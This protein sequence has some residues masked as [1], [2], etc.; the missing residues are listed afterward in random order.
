VGPARARRWPAWRSILRTLDI[1]LRYLASDLV[2]R[3]GLARAD[4]LLQGWS[5]DILGYGNLQL[6]TRG[7][8]VFERHPPPFV[9][10]SNHAS[11]LD[12]PVLLL[13]VPHTLR[14][15]T[16]AE[17]MRIPIWGRAMMRSGF[18]PIDRRDRARAIAQLETAK[19]LLARGVSVW[20]SPEGTRSRDGALQPF[21]KGGFHLA[22]DLGLPILP[23]WIEGTH[24]ALRPDSF[25]VNLDTPIE[26]R[27]GQPIA[28]GG[29]GA[30][31]LAELMAQV[32]AQL[33]EL[34]AM[35]GGPH[36]GAQLG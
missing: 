9:V 31:E 27:F 3:G 26:V 29:P 21:K 8:E 18:I 36:G 34:R 30:P 22:M 11:L 16:K 14:M 23:A 10:M 20:I 33:L 24:A 12:V 13:T 35:A 5:R 7:R 28:T 32:Q 15:V 1:S 25:L 19:A 17:L 6:G 4:E 2:G